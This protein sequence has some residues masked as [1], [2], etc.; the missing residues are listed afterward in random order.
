MHS[1]HPETLLE[2]VSEV[3]IAEILHLVRTSTGKP[4]ADVTRLEAARMIALGKALRDAYL[5]AR[6]RDTFIQARIDDGNLAEGLLRGYL[7]GTPEPQGESADT[8]KSSDTSN[9][10][11]DASPIQDDHEPDD[12]GDCQR[13]FFQI[14]LSIGSSQ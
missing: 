13:R 7:D 6:D 9:G 8:D 5:N 12:C 14:T 1:D 3:L 4:W 2:S 10:A 11:P